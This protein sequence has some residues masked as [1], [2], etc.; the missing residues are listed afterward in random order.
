[1]ATYMQKARGLAYAVILFCAKR[2][3]QAR[4]STPRQGCNKHL[5]SVAAET[6]TH[7]SER[8]PHVKRLVGSPPP[9]LPGDRGEGN[10]TDSHC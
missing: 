10:T 5:P 1:M 8:V 3:E 7:V 4:L 9:C 6:E 2:N